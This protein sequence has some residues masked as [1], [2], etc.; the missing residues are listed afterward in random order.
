MEDG[1]ESCASRGDIKK[2]AVSSVRLSICP[3]F[4][5]ASVRQSEKEK[6]MSFFIGGLI[7]KRVA[8][9]IKNQN[10]SILS[11]HS[12]E[13]ISSP[14][15]NTLLRLNT[16]KWATLLRFLSLAW[17]IWMFVSG[18]S[19]SS[20]SSSSSSDLDVAARQLSYT[21]TNFVRVSARNQD[22][23]PIAIQTYPLDGGARRR[24]SKARQSVENDADW[25][26]TPFP[27]LYWLTCPEISKNIAN[28]ERRGFVKVLEDELQS[29]KDMLQS[30]MLAHR[31]YARL[32]WESLTPEDRQQLIDLSAQ[33]R[34]IQRMRNMIEA[35]GIAGS[36]L[37][38]ASPLVSPTI[39]CLHTHYA[40]YRSVKTIH[41]A[42]INPVGAR[43]H[44]LL[45]EIDPSLVL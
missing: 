19:S 33:S 34:T 26:G 36:N 9:S 38:L 6:N 30:L 42:A 3:T 16:M 27:T 43:V 4:D 37:T 32:R 2:S 7:A 35:S 1:G 41:N 21:P 5:L 28:L 23:R 17:Y 13:E 8:E 45:C 31:D 40:H 10:S 11:C 12:Q 22:G 29:N 14:H 44:E 25:L 20:S 18:L 24:Q 15:V 39:K